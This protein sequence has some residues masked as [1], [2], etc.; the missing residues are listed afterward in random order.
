MGFVHVGARQGSEVADTVLGKLTV[1]HCTQDETDSD[2]TRSTTTHW[3]APQ[4]G[5]PVRTSGTTTMPWGMV[6]A[7][8]TDLVKTTVPL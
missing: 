1:W 8:N 3:F 6:M 5:M 7:L 4:L 2:G